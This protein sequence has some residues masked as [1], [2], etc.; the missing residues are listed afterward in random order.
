VFCSCLIP[1]TLPSS[2]LYLLVD[3]TKT[4]VMEDL[5]QPAVNCPIDTLPDELLSRI[6]S[7]A[8]E[9]HT[10][11]THKWYDGDGHA[12]WE[13]NTPLEDFLFSETLQSAAGQR[14]PK[15]QIRNA[16]LTCRRWSFLILARSNSHLWLATVTLFNRVMDAAIQ[17]THFTHAI[18]QSQGCDIDVFVSRPSSTAEVSMYIHALSMLHRCRKQLRVLVIP[19][20]TTK[21]ELRIQQ[22]FRGLQGSHR[23][24]WIKLYKNETPHDHPLYEI[25]RIADESWLLHP[26]FAK[27]LAKP[28][29]VHFPNLYQLVQWPNMVIYC[30]PLGA[31]LEHLCLGYC[32]WNSAEAPLPDWP[33]LQQALSSCPRLRRL[34]IDIVAASDLPGPGQIGS[35]YT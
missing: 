30:L 11:R 24:Q 1:K 25:V 19:A 5:T 26:I 32:P 27:D 35:I 22:F 20:V 23:L 10:V 13:D 4:A 21:M 2:I 33:L 6:F 18:K 14:R 16:M 29:M 8:C 31:S 28:V 9:E 12:V 34:R 15:H 7:I 17:F 3:T